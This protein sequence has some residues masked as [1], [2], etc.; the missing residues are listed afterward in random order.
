MDSYFPGADEAEINRV[1]QRKRS[2]RRLRLAIGDQHVDIATWWKDR[3]TVASDAPR[4]SRGFVDIYDGDTHLVHG[5]IYQTA[6]DQ[7]TRHYAFKSMS[8]A[9]DAPPADFVRTRPQPAGLLAA[10]KRA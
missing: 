1:N 7:D 10:P 4:V 6:E 9:S 8:T 3:L 5:L 2:R